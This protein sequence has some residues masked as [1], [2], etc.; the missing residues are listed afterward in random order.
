MKH[1]ERDLEE[2]LPIQLK[3]RLLESELER[4]ESDMQWL[5]QRKREIVEE[6]RYY[7]TLLSRARQRTLLRRVK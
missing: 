2:F 4:L 7:E 3:L 6:M 5:T 1:T